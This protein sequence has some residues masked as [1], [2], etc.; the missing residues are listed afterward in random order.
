MIAIT[1]SVTLP[2]PDGN[3]NGALP[4]GKKNYNLYLGLAIAAIFLLK[5]E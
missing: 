2:E 4:D 5:G 1:K 3:G